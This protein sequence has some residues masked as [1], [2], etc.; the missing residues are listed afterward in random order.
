MAKTQ[1]NLRSAD[2]IF[3]E[4]VYCEPTEAM[5]KNAIQQHDMFMK[6]H[7]LNA[8]QYLQACI[9]MTN[10]CKDGMNYRAHGLYYE[11]N[12]KLAYDRYLWDGGTEMLLQAAN[13]NWYISDI[14]PANYHH[15]NS[16][17]PNCNI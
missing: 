4:T 15:D 16:G 14:L 13:G 1:K 8:T 3:L 2:D 10:Y 5:V 11:N 12:M 6:D 17:N 7:Q 9:E